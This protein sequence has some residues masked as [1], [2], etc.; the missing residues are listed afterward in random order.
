[1]AADAAVVAAAAV[2]PDTARLVANLEVALRIAETFAG[3]TWERWSDE[4]HRIEKGAR[5]VIAVA[6]QCLQFGAETRRGAAAVDERT[7][8]VVVAVLSRTENALGFVDDLIL[9]D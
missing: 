1:M 2:V 6:V 3:K 7:V 8:R 9:A 5:N 4:G